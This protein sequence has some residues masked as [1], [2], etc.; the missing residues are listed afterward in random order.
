FMTQG[1]ILNAIFKQKGVAAGAK[2]VQ[3][4]CYRNRTGVAVITKPSMN[5]FHPLLDVEAIGEAV[6]RDVD[7][8][9]IERL[10]VDKWAERLPPA[11]LLARGD[12]HWRAIA[13]PAISVIIVGRKRLFQPAD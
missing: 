10:T 7:L 1:G 11:L 12:W 9:H 5:L 4:G 6:S 13:Q 2:P 3:T 8:V